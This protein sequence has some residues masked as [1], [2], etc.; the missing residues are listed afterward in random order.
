MRYTTRVLECQHLI[1]CASLLYSDTLRHVGVRGVSNKEI[2]SIGTRLSGASAIDLKHLCITTVGYVKHSIVEV[3]S[4]F[5]LHP[6][7]LAAITCARVVKIADKI[8]RCLI[9]LN[10]QI[11]GRRS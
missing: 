4:R 6:I 9:R 1:T 3:E 11:S 5:N 7:L 2:G 8:A 10:V